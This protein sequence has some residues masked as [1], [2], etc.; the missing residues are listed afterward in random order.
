MVMKKNLLLKIVALNLIALLLVALFWPHLMISPGQPMAAH[1][2]IADDCFA[3]HSPFIGATPNQCISCHAVD[4]IGRETVDGRPITAEKKSVAFHQQLVEE[5]CLACHS[6]HR[7]VQA[8]RPI[9]RFSHDLLQASTREQ[10]DGCHARPADSLHRGVEGDCDTCHTNAAWTPATFDHE[11]H[12]RFDRHH[13]TECATCHIDNDYSQYTCYG[14]HEHSRSEIREEHW[15]EGIRDY[16]TCVDCHRSGDEDEAE[17][18][19]R[20]RRGTLGSGSRDDRWEYTR[21]RD[22]DEERENRRYRD[23]DDH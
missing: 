11:P 22:D 23:P 15:E 21:E 9:S 19:W 10:C 1:A 14:C 7:G 20:Q 6:E 8:F 18:I 4:R 16:E 17:Y 13:T 5:D 12:F 3:C 2:N